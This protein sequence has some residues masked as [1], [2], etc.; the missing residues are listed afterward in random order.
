MAGTDQRVRAELVQEGTL[1]LG[2][3]PRMAE[4][5]HEN[6]MTLASIMDA[7]GWPSADMVGTDGCDAAWLVLQHSIGDPPVMRRGLA[8]LQAAPSNAVAPIQRAMLEDRVRVMSGLPQRYGTQFDWSADGTFGPREIEDASHVDER[9]RAIGL[10]PLE[11]KIREMREQME[12]A[13]QQAPADFAE[14]RRE[15]EQWEISVGWH[16]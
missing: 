2:Y 14:R 12:R 8:L 1:F 15:I 10:P 7:V 11:T 16:A 4:V 3:H 9:R 5:H 6:A 13:R